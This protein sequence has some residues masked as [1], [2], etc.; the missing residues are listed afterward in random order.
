M[1][2]HPGLWFTLWAIEI[3][4]LLGIAVSGLHTS[5]RIVRLGLVMW[6]ALVFW[7]M[8]YYHGKFLEA[9][10]RRQYARDMDNARARIAVRFDRSVLHCYV[11]GRSVGGLSDVQ[12]ALSGRAQ[13]TK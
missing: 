6:L 8:T 4:F 12:G 2:K 9:Q 3:T 11:Q 10:M 5:E 1:K 13:S 7:A